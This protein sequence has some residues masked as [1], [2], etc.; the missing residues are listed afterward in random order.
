MELT[1]YS[2]NTNF[3]HH[4]DE[5]I[6]K[7]THIYDSRLNKWILNDTDFEEHLVLN[8]YIIPVF[9]AIR[10]I[11]L[12]K[13]MAHV[14]FSDNSNLLQ[15]LFSTKP[16]INDPVTQS[17]DPGWIRVRTICYCNIPTD[18]LAIDYDWTEYFLGQLSDARHNKL[19]IMEKAKEQFL[20]ARSTYKL[21]ST[22]F[23]KK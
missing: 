7:P 10:G 23:P 12:T 19:E 6:C 17:L 11:N 4:K 13:L 9:Q 22:M 3:L 15:V 5:G 18:H 20:E 2:K 21:Y 14:A 16:I 8:Q 1:F